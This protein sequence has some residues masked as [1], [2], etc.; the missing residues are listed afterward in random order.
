MHMSYAENFA[1]KSS[2]AYASK[3]ALASELAKMGARAVTM[4]AVARTKPSDSRA[5]YRKLNG[6]A[7]QSGQTPTNHEWF[8]MSKQ[9]RQHA[10]FLLICYAM[11]RNAYE[12][13]PDAHGT[14][15][16]LTYKN[17]LAVCGEAP[18]ISPE[19]LVLLISN[20]FSIGWRDILSGGASKFPSENMRVMRCRACKVPHLAEAH[21]RTYECGC[22]P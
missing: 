1:A 21:F 8:L 11:Y 16:T 2:L 22:K 17:Y 15:F 19:R 4:T 9:L 7:S 12:P 18:P 13:H 20:G 14:A 10:A 6:A 5:I 3:V